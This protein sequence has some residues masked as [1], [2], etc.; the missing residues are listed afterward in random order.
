VTLERA[1]CELCRM[2]KPVMLDMAP[3]VD[4]KAWVLCSACWLWGAAKPVDKQAEAEAEARANVGKTSGR[5]VVTG[6]RF[7]YT[8]EVV[9]TGRRSKPKDVASFDKKP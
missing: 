7:V 3:G 9:K 4:G 6:E 8:G 2:V 1:A 5:S